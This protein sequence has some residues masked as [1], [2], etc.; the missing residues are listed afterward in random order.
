MRQ[1]AGERWG[2]R[3]PLTEPVAITIVYFYR[4]GAGDVDNIIKPILDAMSGLVYDDDVR[5]MQVTARKTELISGLDIRDP[6]PDLAEAVDGGS[7]FVY[8][9]IDPS[10]DETLLP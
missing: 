4:F 7:D 10:P 8:I 5:V 1:A 3:V 9:R 6:D 2:D